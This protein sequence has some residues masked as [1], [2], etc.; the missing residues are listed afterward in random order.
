MCV[1]ELRFT[2]SALRPVSGCVTTTLC[3]TGGHFSCISPRSSVEWPSRIAFCNGLV[4]SWTARE[5][6]DELAHRG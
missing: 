1:V 4:M 6:V 3:S 2:N 5:A